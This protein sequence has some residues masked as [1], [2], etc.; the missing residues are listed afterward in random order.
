VLFDESPVGKIEDQ[1]PIERVELPVK[2]AERSL[3]TK[4]S[5]FDAPLDE[6]VAKGVFGNIA[7]TICNVEVILLVK[8]DV[9]WI[10]HV[11]DNVGLIASDLVN[12][13]PKEM[14]RTRVDDREVVLRVNN[15]ELSRMI[16]VLRKATEILVA[17]IQIVCLPFSDLSVAR[18]L[19]AVR[20]D[21]R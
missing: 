13:D 17:V 2:R 5:R 10:P 7:A 6:A 15:G 14:I 12:R 9:P 8:N 4:S 16:D 19:H 21:D 20:L 3:V 1:R 11:G 18:P